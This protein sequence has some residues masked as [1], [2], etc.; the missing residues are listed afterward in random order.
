[1]Y[2]PGAG[3]LT[4]RELI[5]LIDN[6]KIFPADASFA[7]SVR[8]QIQEI[9]STDTRLWS[10]VENAHQRKNGG[11]RVF[12]MVNQERGISVGISS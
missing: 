3:L 2:V 7:D 10:A 5:K 4:A 1:M 6:E 11:D 9:Y 8:D 12:I